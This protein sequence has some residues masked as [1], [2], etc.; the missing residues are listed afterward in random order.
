MISGFLF[1]TFLILILAAVSLFM[2]DRTSKLADIHGHIGQLQIHTLLLFKN[3]NDFFDLEATN[4]KYFTTH[5][6]LFLL[7]RY[8]LLQSVNHELENVL[9]DTNGDRESIDHNLL[10]IDSALKLY[11][12]KFMLLEKLVFDKGLKDHGLE[13]QMRIHAHKLEDPG[14]HITITDILTLR[15]HEKDFFLRLDT[16]YVALFRKRADTLLASLGKNEKSNQFEI[17]HLQEY[18]RFFLGLVNVHKQIGLTSSSGLRNELNKL[19]FL[20]SNKYLDLAKY[21]YVLSSNAQQRARIFYL[22]LL[23][24]AITFSILSGVW[25]SRKLSEPIAQL[26]KQVRNVKDPTTRI[27]YNLKKGAKEIQ[28]LARAFNQMLEK[29]EQ[30]MTEIKAKSKLL[31]NKNKQLNRL[32][33]ELDNFLYSTAHDL[34]SPLASLMGLINLFHYETERK[35]IDRYSNMMK[36]SVLRME[37]F[38]AQIVSYSKNKSM[39]LSIVRIDMNKILSNLIDSHKFMDQSGRIKWVLDIKEVAPVY[40]DLSRVTILL[41]NLI[42]NAIKYA[43]LQKEEPVIRIQVRSDFDY[44]HIQFVDNGIGISQEHIERIFDMFYRADLNSKGSGLGLYI[45]KQTVKRMKGFVQVESTQGEGTK[46]VITIPNQVLQIKNEES[47][48]PLS[49]N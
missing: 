42:S 13:G 32:N 44:V 45:L 8:N 43:D 10:S 48:L 3:D 11:D 33:K 14:Y 20:I 9:H 17:Y 28:V 36:E 23:V 7:K 46:F 15:R 27:D 6:S 1:L 31:K 5:Q 40:T 25:I 37:D 47:K 30:Q 22:I 4:E 39:D 21:S 29:S 34:R 16:A 38:I 2:L 19:T 18:K 24:C 12:Q 26:S 49:L 41:N 35:N